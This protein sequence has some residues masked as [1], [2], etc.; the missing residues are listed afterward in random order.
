M[1]RVPDHRNPMYDPSVGLGRAGIPQVDATKSPLG[2]RCNG[3]HVCGGGADCESREPES[4][5][6]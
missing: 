5:L 1:L 3:E 2:V 6:P 4:I